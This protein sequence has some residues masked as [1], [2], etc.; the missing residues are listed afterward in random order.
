MNISLFL[1]LSRLL[2][3][4]LLLAP[5]IAFKAPVHLAIILYWLLASTDFFDGFFARYFKQVTPLG[6]FLDQFSDKVFLFSLL[7]ATVYTHQL[8]FLWALALAMRELLVIG[9]REY[10]VQKNISLPVIF[11][12]KLKT[13]FQIIFFGWILLQSNCPYAEYITISLFYSTLFLSY[14][15]AYFYIHK[16]RK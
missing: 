15:S 5:L 14:Y 16:I 1:T 9:L 13:T 11:S 8:P 4:P 7:F 2:L 10:G 3:S 6:A 12:A